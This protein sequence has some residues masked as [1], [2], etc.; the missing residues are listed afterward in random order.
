LGELTGTSSI[1]Y[2][3]KGDSVQ[4]LSFRF[5]VLLV[6]KPDLNSPQEANRFEKEEI[7]K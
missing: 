1:V 4:R 7:P 3:G 5:E 2:F 6:S